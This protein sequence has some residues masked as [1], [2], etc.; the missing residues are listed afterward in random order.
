MQ[1]TKCIKFGSTS[2]RGGKW[3]TRFH[4]LTSRRTVHNHDY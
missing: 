2:G 1:D 3:G 4:C